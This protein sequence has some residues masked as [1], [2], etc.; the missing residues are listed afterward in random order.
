MLFGH[1]LDDKRRDSLVTRMRLRR[2]R[3]FHELIRDLP[4]PVSILDVG[5][6]EWFWRTMGVLPGEAYR[7]TLLN[8]MKRNAEDAG[9][10]CVVGNG[11]AMREFADGPFSGSAYFYNIY[12]A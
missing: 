3:L 4:G 5:G 10:K 6:T 11:C 8:L 12:S 2:F 9:F 7:I 1:M